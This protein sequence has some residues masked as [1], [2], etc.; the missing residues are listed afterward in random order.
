MAIYSCLHGRDFEDALAISDCAFVSL[1]KGA[2]CLCV[3]SKTYSYMMQGLPLLAIMDESDLTRDIDA[4]AGFWM[5]NG[6]SDR[7]AQYI[8]TLR[9]D[10][11][12]CGRMGKT[13][14]ELYLKKYTREICTEKYVTLFQKLLKTGE[15][16]KK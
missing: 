10:A 12:L 13:S 15:G 3:P 2:T 16:S 4:R 7:L 14:R 11:D 6:E 5:H 8:R 9:D 1:E